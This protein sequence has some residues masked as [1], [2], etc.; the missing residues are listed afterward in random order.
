MSAT[1]QNNAMSSN[2]F[3][4]FANNSDL[5]RQLSSD[6]SKLKAQSDTPKAKSSGKKKVLA[7]VT[8]LGVSKQ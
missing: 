3:V 8:P 7:A 5:E 1:M 6:E 2:I 4:N